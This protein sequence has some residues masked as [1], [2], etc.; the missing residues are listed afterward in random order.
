[1]RAVLHHQHI[2]T[3]TS[4]YAEIW[5]DSRSIEAFTMELVSPN[6]AHRGDGLID[7]AAL[8][9]YQRCCITASRSEQ[10]KRCTIIKKETHIQ[11]ET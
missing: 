9:V 8:Q 7:S 10:K 5:A 6:G 1:M 4:T 2:E 3:G 11:E